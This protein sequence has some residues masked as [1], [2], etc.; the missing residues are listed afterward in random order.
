MVGVPPVAA[1]GAAGDRPGRRGVCFAIDGGT[2]FDARPG[3]G[4]PER[5]PREDPLIEKRRTRIPRGTNRVNDEIRISP[6]RL[7][8]ANGDQLGIVPLDE[9]RERAGDQGLDLV[10]VAAGARPPVVRIMDWGKHLYEQQKQKREARKRQHTVV[11]KEVKFRPKTDDHD[12]DFKVRNARRFLANGKHVKV[13]VRFRR[14]ELRR[15]EL[16]AGVL[17]EVAARTEDLAEVTFRSRE[18]QGNQL[19]MTLEPTGE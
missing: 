1:P 19:V 9:A 2:G 13:T 3:P 10:E 4:R 5:P 6:V 14:R 17:D 11:V 7:V 18:V 16:G 15:P 12:L 8:D